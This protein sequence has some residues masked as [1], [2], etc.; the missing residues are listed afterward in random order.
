MRILFVQPSRY[1]QDGTLY[2][3]RKR[4]LLGMTLPYVAALTPPGHDLELVD[5]CYQDVDFDTPR[6][7][8]AMTCMSHQSRRAYELAQGFRK[9]GVPVVM[10]GFHVSLA[11]EEALEHV[12]SIVYGEAEGAWQQLVADAQRGSLK[13]V[14]Q[15][16]G[17]SDLKG[18]P[19][20][21]YDLIDLSRYRI[22]NLPVQTTRGCPYGCSYCEVTEIYGGKYRFRPLPE[23]IDEL[24]ELSARHKR[25]F[26]YFVDDLF[27]GNKPRAMELMEELGRM[28]AVWTCQA[29]LN[30]GDDPE[31]LEAMRRTGCVHLNLGMETITQDSLA[32][33]NK[34]Q[35]KIAKYEE[36][37]AKIRASGIDFSLNVMF[38]LEGDDPS[39]FG[40]TVD[41]LIRQRAPISYMF[42]L[43]PRPGT[44]VRHQMLRE[45]RILTDDW[46]LYGG[47]HTTFKPKRMSPEALTEGF[48]AAQRRFYSYGSILRRL[49]PFRLEHFWQQLVPNIVF[50]FAVRRHRH[51]VSYY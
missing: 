5:D 48:W 17:P 30:L 11:P 31:V 21:R 23:V 12:D 43:A 50:H 27:T 4:W 18:F 29:T 37:L 39:T 38:G 13:R 1:R 51:P 20:P 26:I 8:V 15:S 36:Q 45:G 22:P 49:F 44:K 41:F 47:Y 2:K 34:K 9:R 46:S 14:Y 6:D 16:D 35:N 7:L 3:A 19:A 24:R 28:G 33:I 10:G 25:R 40:R 42:I 32:S